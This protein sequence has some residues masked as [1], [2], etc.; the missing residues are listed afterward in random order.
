MS[1]CSCEEKK[2]DY[3]KLDQLL[4]LIRGSLPL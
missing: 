2:I 3:E 1:C 4:A